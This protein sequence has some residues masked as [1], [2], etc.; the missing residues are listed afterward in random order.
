MK[1]A[2]NHLRGI[3]KMYLWYVETRGKNEMYPDG[4]GHPASGLVYEEEL[5]SSVCIKS[6][7][8]IGGVVAVF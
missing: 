5:C 2:E 7:S 6:C 3:L 4:G 8:G 1:G